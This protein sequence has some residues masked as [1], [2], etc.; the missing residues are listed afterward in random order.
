MAA[1][2]EVRGEISAR[3]VKLSRG[4]RVSLGLTGLAGGPR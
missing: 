2:E 4:R 1:P 3:G